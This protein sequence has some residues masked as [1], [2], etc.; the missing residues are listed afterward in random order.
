MPTDIHVH[1]F[2]H[3]PTSI[4]HTSTTWSSN[5]QAGC[6]TSMLFMSHILTKTAMPYRYSITHHTVFHTCFVVLLFQ[7]F[8]KKYTTRNTVFQYTSVDAPHPTAIPS[9]SLCSPWNS[10][11][12]CFLTTPCL[13]FPLAPLLLSLY[14][15]ILTICPPQLL[16]PWWWWQHVPPKPNFKLCHHQWITTKVKISNDLPLAVL[17]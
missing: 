14:L 10:Q 17:I 16:Q 7:Q 6:C 9:T 1:H 8:K 2:L 4:F 15:H 11:N 5:F 12:T 3:V 13:L